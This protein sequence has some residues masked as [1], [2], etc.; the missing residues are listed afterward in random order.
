MNAFRLILGLLIA[1][2]LVV[3]G[4]QNTQSVSF[5]FLGWDTSSIPVVL[6]LAIALALGV[7]VGWLVSIPGRFRGRRERRTLQHQVEAQ[8]RAAAPPAP[9][10]ADQ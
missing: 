6:A 8:D 5:H 4:A 7:L 10:S 9:D 1:T 3:F 2:M